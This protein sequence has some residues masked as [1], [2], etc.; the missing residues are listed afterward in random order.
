MN[1]HNLIFVDCE[2]YGPA[3][4]L[5]DETLFEFGAVDYKSKQSFHGQ[6]ATKETFE[7]FGLWLNQFPG[8]LIFVSDNPAYDWQFINY[9]FY[10]FLGRNPFGH[11]ARR[12]SD[13]YAGMKGNFFDSQSWKKWRVTK[14]DHNPIHDA[15]GNIEAFE[16]ILALGNKEQNS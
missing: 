8:R 15:P 5:N 12:I 3:P 6:D 7:K 10:K 1:G 9:C 2:G 11:S 16:K 14:H 4:T 13:F